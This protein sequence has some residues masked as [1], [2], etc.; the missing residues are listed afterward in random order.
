MVE[1]R[2]PGH[3]A[4]RPEAEIS[5]CRHGVRPAESQLGFRVK[6]AGDLVRGK[7]GSGGTGH[8]V[9]RACGR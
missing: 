2:L 7:L 3:S 8:R 6:D 4:G 9:N 1:V 5:C